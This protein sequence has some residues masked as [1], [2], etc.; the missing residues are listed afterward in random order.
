MYKQP[1]DFD[2]L[3]TNV[4]CGQTYIMLDMNRSIAYLLRYGF[5]NYELYL[6]LNIVINHYFVALRVGL[7]SLFV[8]HVRTVRDCYV[9]ANFNLIHVSDYSKSWS[10]E[11]SVF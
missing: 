8:R 6:R 7:E 1:L 2:V 9:C 10:T 4:C 3:L 5:N 11:R